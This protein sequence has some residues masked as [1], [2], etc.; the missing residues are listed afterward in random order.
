MQ[1]DVLLQV[2]LFEEKK[3]EKAFLAVKV[4]C[5]FTALFGISEHVTINSDLDKTEPQKTFFFKKR[6]KKKKR[7]EKI[8][9]PKLSNEI[10][11]GKFIICDGKRCTH[12]MLVSGENIGQKLLA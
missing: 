2:S 3:I 6:E 9:I 4:L 10:C 8:L 1:C 5:G 7:K 11:K 12:L